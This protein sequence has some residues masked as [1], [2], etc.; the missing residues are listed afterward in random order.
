MRSKFLS[1]LC[2]SAAVAAGCGDDGG[3]VGEAK[4]TYRTDDAT[5]EVTGKDGVSRAVVKTKDGEAVAEV[6]DGELTM[7]S[8]KDTF[9]VGAKGTLADLKVAAYPGA[10]LEGDGVLVLD[11]N[12]QKQFT[13]TF[14]TPDPMDKIVAFYKEQ[15]GASAQSSV[16]GDAMATVGGELADGTTI[17]ANVMK[18]ESGGH[19]I[20]VMAL[21]KP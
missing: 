20:M 13:A 14:H 12:G 19:D 17:A 2:V 4:Q 9:S 16:T 15:I 21:P 3:G 11:M 5:V 18:S 6:K 7:T 8:G 10:T 1:A